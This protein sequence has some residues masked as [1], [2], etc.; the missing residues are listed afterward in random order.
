[1]YS[2]VATERERKLSASRPP[3][4]G[5]V[6]LVI[7][8]FSLLILLVKLPGY[9]L[10]PLPSTLLG[11][12]LLVVVFPS[13]YRFKLGRALVWA[14]VASITSGLVLSAT[15]P[16]TQGLPGYPITSAQIL[17]W[18]ISLPVL[19]ALGVWGLER[20]GI[21]PGIRLIAFGGL[22]SAIMLH[23]DIH[24]KGSVGFYAT[25]LA[26]SMVRQRQFHKLTISRLV[27]LAAI[28]L[29]AV[30]DA[31]S[32]VAVAGLVLTISYLAQWFG[33]RI[34]VHPVLWGAGIAAFLVGATIGVQ[35]AMAKGLFGRAIQ[36]RFAAQTE[37]GKLV[38]EAG[39]SEWSA[40]LFLFAEKPA[41]FGLGTVVDEG[42]VGRSLSVVRVAGGDAYSDYF[43]NL[44]FGDRVDLHSIFA[45]LWFHFGLGGVILALVMILTLGLALPH[46]LGRPNSVAVLL[47]FGVLSASWDLMFSPMAN[48]DRLIFGIICALVALGPQQGQS[49]PVRDG[50]DNANPRRI[51]TSRDNSLVRA[52]QE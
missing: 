47:S 19:I 3:V 40:T 8:R 13:L 17:G 20:V 4:F 38:F 26:L 27:L 51:G 24:W 31:R 46:I 12:A 41:G 7:A 37:G 30:N 22:L 6:E 33:P 11:L 36:E 48:S 35:L 2:K 49:N 44:V 18:L 32:M 39:R 23:S 34:K 50:L 21:L 9:S 14:A 43:R 1:M 52:M 5:G 16:F 28:V 42:L 10:F 45:N 15:V 29:G 25:I